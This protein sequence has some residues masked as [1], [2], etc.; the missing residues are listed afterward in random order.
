M[1]NECRL[2]SLEGSASSD[3]N[4]KSVFDIPNL[5]S[6]DLYDV[7]LQ[8]MKAGAFG[9]LPHLKWLS[10]PKNNLTEIK[11]NTFS[12]Q[13]IIYLDLSFKYSIIV[14]HPGAFKNFN[15]NLL[16]LANNQLTEFPS[17]VFENVT[18]RTLILAK[19]LLHTIAPKTLSTIA[20]NK[21]ALSNNIFDEI[22]PESFDMQ[23]LIALYFRGNLVKLLRPGDL[24]NLSELKELWLAG[25]DLEEI[26][27]GVFN[28]TKLTVLNLNAKQNC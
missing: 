15:A 9:N 7:G 10:L 25:N 26:P 28:N 6:L 19:N 23:Q 5:D 16:I 4:E 24:R 22:N 27:E 2:K 17:G 13:K 1:T 20:L 12:D 18:I 11:T 8:E 14:L 3:F 21:L